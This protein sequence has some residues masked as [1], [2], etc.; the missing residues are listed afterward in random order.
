VEYRQLGANGPSVSAITFGAW[1]IGGGLG[2]VD[3]ATA[4]A[5]VRHALGVGITAIDTAEFYRDSEAILGEALDGYPRDRLFLATKVSIEPFTRQRIR[6]ALD[7]SLRALRTDYVDLYQLHRYPTGVPLEEALTGLVDAID[8]GKARYVGT[9]MFSAQ[10]LAACAGF[11][12]Q[13]EQ[14]RLN[15]LYPDATVD[16]LPYCASHGIGILGHSTLGKGLLTGRYR[17]GHQ[18]APDDERSGFERFQGAT[19]AAH[20]ARAD[21][22]AEVAREKGASLL[23]LAIAWSLAQ[24]GVTSAI[25]GAKRPEQIDEQLRGVE[26]RL[27]AEDL[28]RIDEIARG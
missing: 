23:Q 4:I 21:R 11:P 8:A 24:P 9:S 16:S 6:E 27:S 25:V 2:S 17:P 15:I 12:I 20:V 19:F 22:L 18:F 26:L 10:Q 5:T 14:P 28:R 1:P 3:K 7:N 13:S